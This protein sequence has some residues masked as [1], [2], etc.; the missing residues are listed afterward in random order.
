L[1]L[2]RF[3]LFYFLYACILAILSAGLIALVPDMALP[4]GK[5]WALFIFIGGITYIAYLLADLGIKRN[6]E[7]GIMAIM[8]SI[9]L[10]MFFSIAFI[11]IYSLK[12]NEM[13]LAFLLDYFSLYFLFSFFEIYSLLR[14]LRSQN[15]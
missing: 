8:G 5:F 9:A 4:G 10:K 15:K 1:N 2:I 11:L 14:N 12:G 7:T 6:P 13:G 3:T